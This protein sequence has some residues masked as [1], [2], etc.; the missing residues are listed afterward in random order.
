MY[1]SLYAEY[2]KEKYKAEDRRVEKETNKDTDAPV[3]VKRKRGQES[4]HHELLYAAKIAI[5]GSEW[6]ERKDG[7]E[8]EN[9]VAMRMVEGLQQALVPLCKRLWGAHWGRC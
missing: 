2:Y 1:G 9:D 3:A 8:S 4:L 7:G 6:L 5:A